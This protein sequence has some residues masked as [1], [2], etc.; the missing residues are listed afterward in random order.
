MSL[1]SINADLETNFK[2]NMLVE[3]N[4][5]VGKITKSDWRGY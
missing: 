2:R 4:L 5:G 3:T 1:R